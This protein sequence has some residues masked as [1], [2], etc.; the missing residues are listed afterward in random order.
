MRGYERQYA[1]RVL[2]VDFV[3]GTTTPVH[4]VIL[5]ARRSSPWAF[6]RSSTKAATTASH[7]DRRSSPRATDTCPQRLTPLRI[8]RS[9]GCTNASLFGH[10]LAQFSFLFS[11]QDHSIVGNFCRK[12]GQPPCHETIHVGTSVQ[13]HQTL[14][15]MGRHEPRVVLLCVSYARVGEPGPTQ[16][17]L[18]VCCALLPSWMIL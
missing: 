17:V 1:S 8:Q 5:I 18:G 15:K 16:T 2:L 9:A 4:T 6:T 7:G 10:P 11:V 12:K 13:L 14:N 3:D